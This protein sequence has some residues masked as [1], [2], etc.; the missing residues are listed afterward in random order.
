M[1]VMYRQVALIF[2]AVFL[3]LPMAEAQYFTGPSVNALGGAGA[4]AR[5]GS[6]NM[7]INPA[8]VALMQTIE[9]SGQYRNGDLS[10]GRTESFYGVSIADNTED[11]LIAGGLTYLNGTKKFSGSLES[12][13]QYWNV[14]LASRLGRLAIGGSAMFLDS[15]VKGDETYK[16]YSGTF[17]LML[18]ASEQLVFGAVYDSFVNPGS[19]VPIPVRLTPTSRLGLRWTPEDFFSVRLDVSRREHENP[20]R[21]GAVHFGFESFANN[22]NIIRFGGRVDDFYKQNFVTAGWGF[23]GPRLKL[24][25]SFEKPLKESNGAMHSVDLL[26]SF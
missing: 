20:D 22:Y 7:L 14:S 8:A 3:T 5:G 4:A 12:Q 13:D 2:F 1:P 17:G 24:N 16:Q 10:G 9:A 11:V 25:Y 19:D 18:L 6:I 26:V 15:A 23:N 21:E